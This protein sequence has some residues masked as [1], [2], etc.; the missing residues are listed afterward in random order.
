MGVPI[1][2]RLG[3]TLKIS[4]ASPSRLDI[5]DCTLFGR[6]VTSVELG[7]EEVEKKTRGGRKSFMLSGSADGEAAATIKC[8]LFQ[9][10]DGWY[11]LQQREVLPESGGCMLRE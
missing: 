11:S 2:D 1:V 10:G 7:G 8:R 5:E 6:N 3:V 9:R 4:C